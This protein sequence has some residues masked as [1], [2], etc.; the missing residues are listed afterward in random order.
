MADPLFNRY[1]LSA[2][3]MSIEQAIS[4]EISSLNE[5][6]IL[7]SSHVDLCQYYVVKYAIEPVSID[8]D[9]IQIDYDDARID[10]SRRFEYGA[11]DRSKS[12]HVTGTRISLFVPFEGDKRLL[13][14]LPST[15][16][17]RLPY[18]AIRRNELVFVYDC[19]TS[20]MER[21]GDE[22]SNDLNNLSKFLD[23]TKR[24][25][26]N[27]NETIE[28]KVDQFIAARRDKL[29]H[30]RDIVE[31]LGFSLKRSDA[32]ATYL[33]PNVK[34]RVTPR[35]PAISSDSYKPE[36]T[37]DMIEYENILSVIS[38]MVLVME[39]SPR[40]FQG[41][42]EEDLRQ[43]FLVQLNGQYEGQVSGETFNYEGKSDILIRVNGRNIFIAECKF[44]SGPSA[45]NKA[46]DQL[47][48]YTSWR[49][50]KTALLIF[51]RNKNMSAVVDKIP[52]IV[53]NH[54][55]F[56]RTIQ[57]VGETGFRFILGHRD[58]P[59]R[60]IIHTVLVFDVPA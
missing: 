45:M 51:N 4:K 54:P 28:E 1:H 52:G 39:R 19:T 48:N 35:L 23:W 14:C 33:T 7:N 43:H 34:R 13:D 56:K 6:N 60:E 12:A 27:F 21:I 30:D 57:C 11:I 24:D 42:S 16:T 25:V 55:S 36:P 40:A 58:D 15:Y 47:L 53:E 3:L 2:F 10:V 17:S 41:M 18:A 9:R 38:N 49:D 20:D 5:N 31:S 22:F 44:W 37:L 8:E 26:V 50:T 46:L 32:P 29:L 59:N